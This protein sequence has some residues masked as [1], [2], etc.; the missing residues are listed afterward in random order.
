MYI[1]MYVLH[2]CLILL[3]RKRR[4]KQGRRKEKEG[5]KKV[6]PPKNKAHFPIPKRTRVALTVVVL[7]SSRTIKTTL[8]IEKEKNAERYEKQKAQA[9]APGALRAGR[10]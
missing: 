2:H 1:N 10:L 9:R 5:K 3:P 8:F 6:Q 7:A 4:D